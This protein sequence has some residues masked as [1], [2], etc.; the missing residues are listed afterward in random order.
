MLS[1]LKIGDLG[2]ICVQDERIGRVVFRRYI[3]RFS[4]YRQGCHPEDRS[5]NASGLQNER[6]PSSVSVIAA[7][8]YLV[9][10]LHCPLD[11]LQK[12][13]MKA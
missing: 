7:G 3:Q 2:K 10:A 4:A 5:Q 8:Q 6:R 11:E 13:Y 9:G 12:S 1:S